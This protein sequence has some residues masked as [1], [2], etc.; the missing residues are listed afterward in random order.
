MIRKALI[1]LAGLA[2]FG[3]ALGL[4]GL[5]RPSMVGAQTPSAIRAIAPAT[6]M[7][8]GEVVITIT[9]SGFSSGGVLETLPQGFSYKQGSFVPDGTNILV[10]GQEFS[11][12]IST[13]TEF[14]YTVIASDTPD[15]YTF[16]GVLRYLDTSNVRHEATVGGDTQ[17]TV[18]VAMGTTPSSS[19]T[20]TPTMTPRPTL[21]TTGPG[22]LREFEKARVS[23]GSTVDV[24]V[25]TSGFAYGG[26]AETLPAGFEY[27]EGSIMPGDT[28]VEVNGQ[29][30]SFI[31]TQ[32]A[33][34]STEFSYQVMAPDAVGEYSFSGVVSYLDANNDPHRTDISGDTRIAVGA[35]AYRT[36]V[37]TTVRSDREAVVTIAT[38]GLTYGGVEETLPAG[39]EYIEGSITPSDTNVEIDGQVLSFVV[40]QMPDEVMEFSYRVSAASSA[41][42]YDFAGVLIYL[43][44]NNDPQRTNVTGDNQVTV[45]AP[46]PTATPTPVPTDP[47]PRRR[48]SGGGGGGGGGYAPVLVTATPTPAP[49][50][51][52]VATIAPT[53]T[54][55]IVPTV[56]PATATPVPTPEPTATPVPTAMPKPTAT[57]R[58]KDTPVIPTV[59]PTKPP[60][61]TATPAPTATSVPPTEVPPTEVPPTA[62]P[63]T[64]VPPTATP[65]PTV[66]PPVTPTEPTGM[67]T[68]LIVLIIVV[69]VGVVIAGVGYYLMRMRR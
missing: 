24:T 32:A 5:F 58:P 39:F 27:V 51:A 40:T 63:P 25:T 28:N 2:V 57:A 34:A 30:L 69:I 7:P 1:L 45:Q 50:R 44:A 33:N 19:P 41:R 53:P 55:I 38:S 59:E 14:S 64:E 10:S 52:P 26:V 49:T 12:I 18:A 54:M 20:P 68:W 3:V 31:V 8:G 65:A 46:P 6:V 11:F 42:T 62:V 4:A 48:R 47:P 37:P 35:N 17:V 13:G 9:T 56:P 15:D 23:P 66:A 60:E 43:D 21:P 22:A 29:V 61:P 67:P 36:I 16:D